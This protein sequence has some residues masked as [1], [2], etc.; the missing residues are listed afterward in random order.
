MM[1][2]LHRAFVRL[3]RHSPS[4]TSITFHAAYGLCMR[5]LLFNLC[6]VTEA[7]CLVVTWPDLEVQNILRLLRMKH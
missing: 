3:L 6:V 2:Y 7:P 1:S 5:Q 4:L